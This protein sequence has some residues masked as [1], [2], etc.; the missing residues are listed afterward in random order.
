MVFLGQ[1]KFTLSMRFIFLPDFSPISIARSITRYIIGK[2]NRAMFSIRSFPTNRFKLFHRAKEKS[3]ILYGNDE[4][5]SRKSPV[6]RERYSDA[7]N[8]SSYGHQ[9]E[10]RT[11]FDHYGGLPSSS[12]DSL[13]RYVRSP[14]LDLVASRAKYHSTDVIATHNDLTGVSYKSPLSRSFLNDGVADSSYYGRSSS[15]ALPKKYG[16]TVGGLEPKSVEYYEEILSPSNPDCLSP[17]DTCRSPLLD[18]YLSRCENGNHNGNLDLQQF[19][20]DKPTVYT[21]AEIVEG[22]SKLLG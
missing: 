3:Y 22:D 13:R 6:D 14:T 10:A 19:N 8:I 15:T 5:S 21:D 16:S 18:I 2:T 9:T 12:H 1:G 20:V 7:L 4:A 17:R 11:L